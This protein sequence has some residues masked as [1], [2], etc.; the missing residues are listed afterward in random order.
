MIT[1]NHRPVTPFLQ[2]FPTAMVLLL[3]FPCHLRQLL[4]FWH[5]MNAMP[6]QT[7]RKAKLFS[8]VRRLYA[9]LAQRAYSIIM[10][11]ALFCTLAVKFFHARRVGFLDAYPSWI[12]DD[13]A[14]LLGV[15]IIL[16]L[17]CFR[18]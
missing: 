11:C 5:T 14:V 15:E 13:V 8:P 7:D 4:V 9:L 1:K 18:C 12:L 10:F 3:L 2:P 6:A 17:L 16:A